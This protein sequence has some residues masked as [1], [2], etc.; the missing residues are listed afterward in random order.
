MKGQVLVLSYS[1][2]LQ[3]DAG[4]HI[5]SINVLRSIKNQG[6]GI[7]LLSYKDNNK[8][9]SYD[10]IYKQRFE[11]QHKRPSIVRFLFSYKPVSIINRESNQYLKEL[12]KLLSQKKYDFI[13]INHFKMLFTLDSL[14]NIDKKKIVYISHNAE[15]LLNRNIFLFDKNIFNRLIYFNEYIKTFFYEKSQLK[16]LEKVIT[17]CENDEKALKK[18]TITP[19]YFI[20][21]PV[22]ELPTEKLSDKTKSYNNVIVA[23]S[24]TWNPKFKNLWYFLKAHN[25]KKILST[26]KIYV[27]GQIPNEKISKLKKFTNV[28]VTGRVSSLEDYYSKC[29]I[30]IVPEKLGGGFKLKIIEAAVNKSLIIAVKGA[31]INSN[32]IN[33]IHYIEARSYDEIYDIINNIHLN[34]QKVETIIDNAYNL[35]VSEYSQDN[36]NYQMQKILVH[37]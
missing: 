20:C 37:S 34:T 24:F 28:I 26:K 16:R 8:I 25:S 19:S 15:Y 30:A 13:F 32:F 5:Y 29:K 2:H 6:Y 36:L 10:G 14:L 35:A 12:Q 7:D 23:G 17:I 22:F 4:D 9:E 11:I 3:M 21:R 33:N 27:V 18:L 31:I 1:N